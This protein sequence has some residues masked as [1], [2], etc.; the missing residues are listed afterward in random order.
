[1]GRVPTTQGD[2]H[3]E[4]PAEGRLEVNFLKYPFFLLT[5]KPMRQM[6]KDTVTNRVSQIGFQD[7]ES[8]T[9]WWVNP[10]AVYGYPGPFDKKVFVTVQQTVM[11]AGLPQEQLLRLGSLRGL[12]RRMGLADSGKNK[13]QI[14]DAL[15]RIAGTEVYT[16][17]TFFLRDQGTYWTESR[18]MGGYFH[19]WDVFWTGEQLPTGTTAECIYLYLNPPFVLSLNAFYLK[20]IDFDYYWGL[21]S[22]VAQRL[23]ELLGLRFY[24]LQTSPYAKYRYSE[25]CTMLPLTR[26]KYLSKAKE[27]LQGAHDELVSTGFLDKLE[28]H[29]SDVAGDWAL[30]YYPGQRARDEIARAKRKSE[31]VAGTKAAQA[32]YT[33][34]EIA[35]G[36]SLAEM[37]L[38]VTRD[39]H[40]RPFYV[41]IARQAM[42]NGALY[43]VVHRVLGEVKED[44]REGRIQTSRGA[45][46]TDRLKRHCAERGIDLGLSSG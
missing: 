10:S 30:H 32:Q 19:I 11:E 43:N 5:R 33:D 29:E 44:A 40:S 20:P 42:R 21:Q 31:L 45:V 4:A 3:V 2:H 12:C 34:E 41:R 13:K 22:P 27:N 28:W 24:G 15:F 14:K 6:L 38:E 26:Q 25:L 35:L 16:Q 46:F 17:N 9:A 18:Q 1:M 37:I 36:D 7:D 8:G 39:E 23:Y